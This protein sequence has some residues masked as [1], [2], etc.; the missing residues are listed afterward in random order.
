MMQQF[1]HLK[2]ITKTV[3]DI[4]ATNTTSLHHHSEYIFYLSQ[5]P[6]FYSG[7]VVK[8]SQ[9]SNLNQIFPRRCGKSKSLLFL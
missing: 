5:Y 3:R 9:M 7:C 4:V 2:V 8:G 6:R 1:L